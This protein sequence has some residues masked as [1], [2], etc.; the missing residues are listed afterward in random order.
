MIVKIPA[1]NGLVFQPEHYEIRGLADTVRCDDEDDAKLIE[2]AL[3]SRPVAEQLAAA[4]QDWLDW[5]DSQAGGRAGRAEPKAVR[6]AL[7]DWNAV[8]AKS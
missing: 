1:E 6:K 7:A 8:I 4:A 3:N 5:A 2:S